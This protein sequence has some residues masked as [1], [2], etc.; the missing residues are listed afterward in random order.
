MKCLPRSGDNGHELLRHHDKE[1]ECTEEI[2]PLV[3]TATL[4]RSRNEV[5]AA[6]QRR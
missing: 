5:P 3:Q 4:N 1:E 2:L 6:E